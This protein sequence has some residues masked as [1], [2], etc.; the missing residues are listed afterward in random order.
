MKQDNTFAD[1]V[2]DSEKMAIKKF[3][4]NIDKIKK[5]NL[6]NLELS[7]IRDPR[8][9]NAKNEHFKQYQ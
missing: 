3:N 8:I 7:S 6:T 9:S 2:I 1:K 5:T 4:L